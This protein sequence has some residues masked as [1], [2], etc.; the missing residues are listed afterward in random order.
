MTY[1]VIAARGSGMLTSATEHSCRLRCLGDSSL[2]RGPLPTRW[3]L[4][5]SIRA[6]LVAAVTYRVTAA[7]V[8][9][10]W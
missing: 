4:R 10:R 9:A 6:G 5:Y 1:R 3:H 8:P 2:H 7:T